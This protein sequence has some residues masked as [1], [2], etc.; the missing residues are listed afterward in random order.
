LHPVASIGEDIPDEEVTPAM[1]GS[2]PSTRELETEEAEQ[3]RGGEALK[4]EC[5]LMR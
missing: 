2:M 1:L 5:G 3:K 4:L